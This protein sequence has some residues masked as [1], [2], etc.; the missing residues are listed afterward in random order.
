MALDFDKIVTAEKSAEEQVSSAKKELLIRLADAKEKFESMVREADE[1]G[2]ML[3]ASAIE[4]GRNEAIDKASKLST[5]QRAAIDALR[6]SAEAKTSKA[7][8]AI[9]EVF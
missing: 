6:K 8:Q 4:S 2:K 9:I 3:V 1:S 7:I 5:A